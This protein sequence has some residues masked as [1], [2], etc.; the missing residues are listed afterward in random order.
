MASILAVNLFFQV[1]DE[2]NW[3]VLLDDDKDHW[4]TEGYMSGDNG[5]TTL[6]NGVKQ[7]CHTTQGWE[8][9]LQWKDRYTS[10]IKIYNVKNAYPIEVAKHAIYTSNILFNL[11]NPHTFNSPIILG[12]IL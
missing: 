4:S 1:D 5:F 2:G 8:L 6:D 10:W 12:K 3:Y 11:K 7:R 9:C